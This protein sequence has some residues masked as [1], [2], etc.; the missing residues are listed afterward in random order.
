MTPHLPFNA[1]Q[2]F[3]ERLNPQAKIHG[4]LEN[5]RS[6]RAFTGRPVAPAL[7]TSLFEAAR[8][9]PSSANEQPWHFIVASKEDPSYA[10]IFGSLTEKNQ[11]W[12][13]NAPFLAA[14][15][16]QT[17]YRRSGAPYQH[18]WYDLGQSVAHLTVQASSLGLVVHQMGGFDE[19]K[20]A[21]AFSLPAGYEPVVVFALGYA[22]GAETLP[23]DLQKRE[24]APRSRR[25]LESFV[26]TGRWG[27][28]SRH[29]RTENNLDA[30]SSTT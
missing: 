7:I 14:A 12:A 11:R 17:T 23:E 5:R 4:L 18:A 19:V 24:E 13:G 9:A 6:P 25:P 3:P 15:V 8:W 16:A 10:I 20:L 1:G 21:E 2:T 28:P 22:A 27:E 30:Q 26:F 29:I